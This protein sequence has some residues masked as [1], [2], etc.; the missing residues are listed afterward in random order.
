MAKKFQE[1]EMDYVTMTL[2]DGT[3]LK[4]GVVAIYPANDR[5]YVALMP[6]D[7]DDNQIGDEIYLYRFIGHGDDQ[8]P[9]L[10]MIA[11]DEEYEIAADAYDELL[12]NWEF[13]EMGE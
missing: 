8:D 4:C 12:D 6:L 3:D 7:D 10:D 9:E 11:D 1:D 13:D 5:Q 2:E